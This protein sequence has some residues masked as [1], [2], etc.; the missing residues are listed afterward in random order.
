MCVSVRA[1]NPCSTTPPTKPGTSPVRTSVGAHPHVVVVDD[2]AVV[3]TDDVDGAGGVDHGRVVISRIPS[4]VGRA[5]RPGHPCSKAIVGNVCFNARRR[6]RRRAHTRAF[7]H[8]GT[9]SHTHTYL[10]ISTWRR[11]RQPHAAPRPPV[12]C[13]R[14]ALPLRRAPRVPKTYIRVPGAPSRSKEYSREYP[15]EF[16]CESG[17]APPSVL[18]HTPG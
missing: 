6:A 11:P 17:H 7:T 14:S 5:A 12:Q 1:C 13:H 3:A 2:A 16:P 4:R 8:T 9:H 10:L 18:T 15:A